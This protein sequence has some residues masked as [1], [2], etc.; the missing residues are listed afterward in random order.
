MPHVVRRTANGA[1]RYSADT[2]HNQ[3]G[4]SVAAQSL[5]PLTWP[6]LL[7][8][9][10]RRAVSVRHLPAIAPRRG[11][12][13]A[14]RRPP[15][16]TRPGPRGTPFDQ[17]LTRSFRL[18]RPTAAM[19][20]GAGSLVALVLLDVRGFRLV[21]ACNWHEGNPSQCGTIRQ[22]TVPPTPCLAANPQELS[23]FDVSCLRRR[24]A[25]VPRT[26][27]FSGVHQGRHSD[28]LRTVG[29]VTL[30]SEEYQLGRSMPGPRRP[31][32]A[33]I[34]GIGGRP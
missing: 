32:R 19:L 4:S 8:A 23:D 29:F 15:M 10:R 21:L 13:V 12:Y 3:L 28:H 22:E 1:F 17:P 25:V 33:Q 27:R 24:A 14:R 2:Q 34:S 6:D 5:S 7:L 31:G 18:A 30:P 9:L 20:L 16:R 26:G 11:T